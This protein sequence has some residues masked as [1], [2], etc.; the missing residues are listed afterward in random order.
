MGWDFLC[1]I[2]S[3]KSLRRLRE[4]KNAD[5][6]VLHETF[7]VEWYL[8]GYE[9]PDGKSPEYWYEFLDFLGEGGGVGGL[10]VVSV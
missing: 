7:A 9:G 6:L 10:L 1:D 4:W 8:E 2:D 5:C 3:G